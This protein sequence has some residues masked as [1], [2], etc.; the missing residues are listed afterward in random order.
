MEIYEGRKL[1]H[2]RSAV[3]C[4]SCVILPLPQWVCSSQK[5]SVSNWFV[6]TLKTVPNKLLSSHLDNLRWLLDLDIDLTAVRP[7]EAIFDWQIFNIAQKS[8]KSSFFILNFFI[9]CS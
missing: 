1:S 9:G 4:F 3:I 7:Q 2:Y 5:V 6:L 8:R